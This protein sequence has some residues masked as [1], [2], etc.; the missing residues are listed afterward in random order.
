VKPRAGTSVLRLAV[1]LRVLLQRFTFLFL[2]IGAFALMMLGKAETVPVER[3][4]VA[5]V[6]F[7]A[8]IMDTLSRPAAT[9]DAAVQRVR[10]L[11]A[12]HGENE[13][14]RRENARLLAWQ[15]AARRLSRQNTA[16]QALLDYVPEPE[17]KYTAARVIGDAG[18]VFI[19]SMLLNAGTRD[20]LAKSQAVVTG[21]GLV[22]RITAVG[23]RSARA[24]LITDLNSRVPV[25][26]ESSRDRA[27]LSGDNSRFPRLVFLPT[28][29]AIKPGDRILTSGHGG[30]FPPALPV[31]EVV[32]AGKGGVRV[33]PYAA[34]D[35]LEF[36]RVVA[37]P[38]IA[39]PDPVEGERR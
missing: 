14:L 6:D 37:Y 29:S 31:G 25:V 34:L 3:V 13:R 17:A 28:N 16:L 32:S 4:T 36:V 10:E 1:P 19:R 5:V 9:I 33:R 24:L 35:R 15:E 12:L 23:K 18:G 21:D 38:G 11:V 8:P 30:M 26:V 27:I 7:V 20:G 2:V 39:R 22:G